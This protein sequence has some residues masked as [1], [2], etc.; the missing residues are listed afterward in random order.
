MSSMLA[1]VLS[2]ALMPVSSGRE[3]YGA[4]FT[5]A[6]QVSFASAHADVESYAGHTVKVEGMIK[7][8][9]QEKGCWIVLTDGKN[10]IRV[11]FKD[12]G[13]FVPK[14]SRGKR[15]TVEGTLARKTI[16]EAAA[17]HYAE[18]SGSPED[19][20]KISGDQVV[21][22]IVATGVEIREE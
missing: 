2:I 4:P 11:S 7:D 1:I 10:Q 18:E 17:K 15:A 14:N 16:P 9:C 6:K 8:V 3:H 13:F 21:I 12:Y 5:N 20:E 22:A 19:A